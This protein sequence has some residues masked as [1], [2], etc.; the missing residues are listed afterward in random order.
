[1]QLVY[2]EMLQTTTILGSSSS[3]E[4]SLMLLKQ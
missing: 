2:T 3:T 1:M 4:R